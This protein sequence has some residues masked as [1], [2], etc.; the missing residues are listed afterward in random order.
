M[1]ATPV[2]DRLKAKAEKRQD[3]QAHHIRCC[4]A[5]EKMCKNPFWHADC[6]PFNEGS[7]KGVAPCAPIPAPRTVFK[8][9]ATSAPTPA[10]NP[11]LTPTPLQKNK[12]TQSETKDKDMEEEVKKMRGLV[13]K[14]EKEVEK[15]TKKM[16][17]QKTFHEECQKKWNEECEGLKSRAADRSQKLESQVKEMADDVAKIKDNNNLTFINIKDEQNALKNQLLVTT[18]EVSAGKMQI[19]QQEKENAHLHQQLEAANLQESESAKTISRQCDEILEL[20]N[21]LAASI[22]SEEGTRDVLN[23]TNA[24]LQYKI[25][26]IQVL[27]NQL[28]LKT[29]LVQATETESAEVEKLQKEMQMLKLE[30]QHH[31]TETAVRGDKTGASLLSIST[32]NARIPLQAPIRWAQSSLA[33]SPR[34][35]P[36]SVGV[37]IT[38]SAEPWNQPPPSI[39]ALSSMT[40]GGLESSG[41]AS[42]D[43][44]QL[45]TSTA[46]S[47]SIRIQ[48]PFTMFS[49]LLSHSEATRSTLLVPSQFPASTVHSSSFSNATQLN[50]PPAYHSSNLDEC[51]M[52]GSPMTS[53]L[54]SIRCGTCF[55]LFHEICSVVYK[56]QIGITCEGCKRLFM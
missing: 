40:G 52:C 1:S 26:E 47:T 45:S 22:N 56:E 29:L 17:K 6:C 9:V 51:A 10:P 7:Q 31:R 54:K 38:D 28:R 30:I 42:L 49:S 27:Q 41:S 11:L 43:L 32:T 23:M 44:H 37:A 2:K 8:P 35:R 16:G 21:K 18:Q 20:K 39:L 34:S 19:Q 55:N 48:Q 53:D 36:T 46:Y 14:M 4:L 5:N 3:D 13:E 24:R 50:Q 15:M 12:S 33:K 25:D